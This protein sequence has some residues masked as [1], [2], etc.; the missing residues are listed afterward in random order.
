MLAGFARIVE[1]CFIPMQT[2][3]IL[4]SSDDGN[5]EQTVASVLENRCIDIHGKM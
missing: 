4:S 3:I 2:D 1:V 5:S